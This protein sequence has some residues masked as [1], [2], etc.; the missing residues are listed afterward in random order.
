MTDSSMIRFIGLARVAVL[1]LTMRSSKTCRSTWIP[2]WQS[3]HS[4]RCNVSEFNL[5]NED[6]MRK[7]YMWMWSCRVVDLKC[8]GCLEEK[9][10]KDSKYVYI[11]DGGKSWPSYHQNS[12]ILLLE[13]YQSV[14]MEWLSTVDVLC[15]VGPMLVRLRCCY[16]SRFA[17]FT[18][19]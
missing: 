1:D 6:E 12:L 3:E 16:T 8:V 10:F 17:G 11:R 9:N 19:V 7:L 5:I 14:Y 2:Q 4:W 18:Q 13:P 15:Q